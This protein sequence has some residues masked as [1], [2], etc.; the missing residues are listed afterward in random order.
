VEG[1]EP[2]RV[3]LEAALLRRTGPVPLSFAQRRLWFLEQ[4]GASAAYHIPIAI[5][6]EGALDRGALVR[7]LNEIAHRHEALRTTFELQNGEPVQVVHSQADFALIDCDL[8]AG[9]DGLA[10]LLAEDARVPFDFTR[11]PLWRAK[12]FQMDQEDHVLAVMFHHIIADG[13]SL[14]VFLRELAALYTA[15]HRGTPSPLLPLPAQYGDFAIWQHQHL[16]LDSQLAFWKRELSGL[17][18]C[19]LS[20]DRPRPAL[21]SYRGARVPVSLDAELVSELRALSH[22]HGATLF[23]TLLAAWQALLHRSGAGDD[24]A[25]GTPIAGRQREELE[26]LIGFFVNTL[27]LRLCQSGCSLRTCRR[28]NRGQSRHFASSAVPDHAGACQHAAFGGRLC[29]TARKLS[30]GQPW[31]LQI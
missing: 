22:K 9:A 1:A 23:I 15:F 25:V 13:W 16:R 29:R 2:Q 17:E 30:R 27:V 18:R 5:R 19:D 14:D 21:P 26:P 20:A 7:A 3:E 31:C 11:G 6:L 28:G 24:I 12:L 4:L 8:R 10:G